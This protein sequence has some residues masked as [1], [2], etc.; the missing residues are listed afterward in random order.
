MKQDLRSAL[1]GGGNRVTPVNS[2]FE[3]ATHVAYVAETCSFAPE[4]ES[5]PNETCSLAPRWESKPSR[6]QDLY[7]RPCKESGFAY[8]RNEACSLAPRGRGLG[9]GGKDEQI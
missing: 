2:G 9:R 3:G 6:G 1:G 8:G 4:W 7:P 5:K